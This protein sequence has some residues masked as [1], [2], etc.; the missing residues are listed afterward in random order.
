MVHLG[1][2]AL[3]AVEIA[4][5]IFLFLMFLCG[6]GLSDFYQISLL[7]QEYG[8]MYGCF[9]FLSLLPRLL[10]GSSFITQMIFV[11]TLF[12]SSTAIEYPP[13]LEVY[14]GLGSFHSGRSILDYRENDVVRVVHSFWVI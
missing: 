4:C 3:M 14:A 10:V 2:Y 8:C 12:L 13:L 1:C 9:N 11:L 7:W 5:L 6:Q